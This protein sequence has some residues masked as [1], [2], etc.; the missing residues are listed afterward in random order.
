MCFELYFLLRLVIMSNACAYLELGAARRPE[1][2]SPP[3][4]ESAL[5][6]A[7]CDRT[8][9]HE[10]VFPGRVRFD[11]SQGKHYVS[12]VQVKAG[13]DDRRREKKSP[14]KPSPSL[15]IIPV[16]QS[17]KSGKQNAPGAARPS[18]PKSSKTLVR[19]KKISFWL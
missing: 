11:P 5:S 10:H 8:T 16:N 12:F 19:Y 7:F 9:R 4:E 13:S 15:Q 2:E 18:R 14:P 3:P 1:G 6:C 17:E